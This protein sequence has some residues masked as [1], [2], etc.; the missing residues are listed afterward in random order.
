[1]S[2]QTV[3]SITGLQKG[4]ANKTTVLRPYRDWSFDMM[5]RV[6]NESNTH[7]S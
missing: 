5:Q 6:S 4:Q 7:W 2:I 1:M 3:I